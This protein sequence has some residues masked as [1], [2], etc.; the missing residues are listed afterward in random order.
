[1]LIVE[2][3]L[4]IQQVLCEYLRDEGFD[5]QSASNGAEALEVARKAPPD[6]AVVDVM[7]PIMDARPMLSSWSEDPMLQTVPVVLVSAAPG[8]VELAQHSVVRAT[9]AKPFDLDVLRVILDQVLAHPEP[10]PDTPVL[11][12]EA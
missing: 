10:P 5:L 3:D 1:M 12:S 8:L 2:D 11:P 6:V 4:A 9:L 7:M